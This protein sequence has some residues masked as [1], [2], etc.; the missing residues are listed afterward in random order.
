MEESKAGSHFVFVY[1]TLMRGERNNHLLK[2]VGAHFMRAAKTAG[3]SYRMMVN[4]SSSSPGKSTPS[5]FHD[6]SGTRIEGQLFRVNTAR[7]NALDKLEQV[8][9]NYDRQRVTLEGGQKAWMY[10]KRDSAGVKNT[11]PHMVRSRL[12]QSVRWKELSL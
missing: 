6:P 4:P 10:I 1:G 11:S 3:A 7:L 9:V 8:G 12:T 5:V 2:G